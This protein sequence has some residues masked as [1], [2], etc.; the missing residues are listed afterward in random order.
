[1]TERETYKGIEFVR[2][3]NLPKEQIERINASFPKEKVIKI[4][5]GEVILNDCIS[6]PDYQEWAKQYN[7]VA[8]TL[9]QIKPEVIQTHSLNF[10][11]K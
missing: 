1:M 6:Y 8:A 11:L 7:P 5:K 4:L 9:P 2:V 3:S 10:V